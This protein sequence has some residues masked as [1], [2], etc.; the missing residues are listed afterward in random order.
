MSIKKS[1]L[2][3]YQRMILNYMK[4]KGYLSL[5][6]IITPFIGKKSNEY[7]T[8]LRLDLKKELHENPDSPYKN[9]ST[10]KIFL[11]ALTNI[12]LFLSVSKLTMKNLRTVVEPIIIGLFQTIKKKTEKNV[13]DEKDKEKLMEWKDIMEKAEDYAN[14]DNTTPKEKLIISLYYLSP[15]RRLEYADLVLINK[16]YPFDDLSNR[17]Y[18]TV[19]QENGFNVFDITINDYK[20]AEHYGSFYRTIDNTQKIWKYWNNWYENLKDNEKNSEEEIPV[21]GFSRDRM[22]KILIQLSTRF[23]IKPINLNM[24]RHNFINWFLSSPRSLELKTLTAW[25]MGH[26]LLTQSEYIKLLKPEDNLPF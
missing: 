26:S 22:G 12:D 19:R 23:L 20:T 24:L 18:L 11:S 4:Y 16:F 14:S 6:Q 9:P 15:P 1:T 10:F 2:D 21:F 25:E 17:N 8:D 3:T 13:I 5:E 7:L